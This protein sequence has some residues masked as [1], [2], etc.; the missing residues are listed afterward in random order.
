MEHSSVPL[1]E[2]LDHTPLYLCAFF[3]RTHTHTHVH[4][5]MCTPAHFTPLSLYVQQTA[6][7]SGAG[8]PQEYFNGGN[9]GSLEKRQEAQAGVQVLTSEPRLPLLL[10]PWLTDGS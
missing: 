2:P 10:T 7:G 9:L 1:L 5:Y 6:V 8:V 4:A 3:T